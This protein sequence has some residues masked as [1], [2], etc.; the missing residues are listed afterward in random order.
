MFTFYLDSKGFLGDFRTALT[1][2]DCSEDINCQVKNF[3]AFGE[4]NSTIFLDKLTILAHIV[5]TSAQKPQNY[6][7]GLF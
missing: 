6:K 2:P 5:Q 4:I 1:T 7:F 3:E